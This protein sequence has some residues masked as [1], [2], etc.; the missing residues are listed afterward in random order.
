MLHD[1]GKQNMPQLQHGYDEGNINLILSSLCTYSAPRGLTP[2]HFSE[3]RLKGLC[4]ESGRGE[5][6]GKGGVPVQRLDR[7][8]VERGSPN[9]IFCVFN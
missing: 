6:R 1:A 8:R 5:G 9:G 7:W 3:G 4:V 2:P